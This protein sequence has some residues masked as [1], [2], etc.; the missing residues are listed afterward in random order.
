L[1]NHLYAS[2]F[3][4]DTTKNLIDT[5]SVNLS[6]FYRN[7]HFMDIA[8]ILPFHDQYLTW[9]TTVIHPYHFDLT[10]MQDTVTLVLA[11]AKDCGFVIPVAGYATSDFGQR[12]RYR[13]HYGIDLKLNTGDSV[14]SAFD[15]IVRISHYSQ[16]YG[17]CVVVR[18]YNGLETLYAHLSGRVVKC[19]EQ[20]LAGQLL[21]YGGT[22]GHST[23]PH[24]HFE[25][26]YLGEPINPNTIINF[27]DS[28]HTLRS[29]TLH[30]T[31]DDFAY[32]SKFHA[33]TR[34]VRVRVRGRHGRYHYVYVRTSAY[35]RRYASR[36]GRDRRGGHR[37]FAS[38]V[39]HRGD[40]ISQ[41]A[42]RNGTTINRICQVNRI[43]RNAK[44]RPGQ[45]LK[46]K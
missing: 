14:V 33:Q 20:V 9:D 37:T 12:N 24:L 34:L 2:D 44:L 18:H 30:I 1:F 10:K 31:A 19:G 6:D 22:T 25:M 13:Y 43:S 46:L 45:R 28:T 42:V 16:S 8:S 21:G 7:N 35:S 39:I 36:Y 17:N 26:R 29:D 11:N 38:Y 41:I 32:L 3:L 15:G 4:A 5:T 40:T 23:G 27:E